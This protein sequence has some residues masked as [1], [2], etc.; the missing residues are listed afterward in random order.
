MNTK[1]L[2][3][4][5]MMT[6]VLVVLTQISLPVGPVPFTL[7]TLAVLLCGF[8][9]GPRDGFISVLVYIL[10]GAIGVPVFAGFS[11]GFSKIVGP[12]GGYLFS[13]LLS[14]IIAGYI[15][16]K[17]PKRTSLY[18]A[19][20][21]SFAVTHTLGIAWFIFIT[22]MPFAKALPLV[23]YPFI[24]PDLVKLVI[25]VNLGFEVRR[26]VPSPSFE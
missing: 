9:L 19:G 5:S 20:L 1:Q 16:A 21:L 17:S 22:R 4:I 11:G 3:R 8:I 6:A 26:R 13:F 15:Y 23:F 18:I 25:A 2:I 10:L 24:I 7:Q 12:T 14:A